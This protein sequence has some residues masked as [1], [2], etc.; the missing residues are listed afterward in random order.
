MNGFQNEHPKKG[1][2]FALY[3][4]QGAFT[5]LHMDPTG[6]STVI[7]CKSGLKLWFILLDPPEDVSRV[8]CL[9]AWPSHKW[10]AVLLRAGDVL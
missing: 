2:T 7:E 3:G 1:F 5:R 9:R 4:Q 10:Q 8:D 6:G